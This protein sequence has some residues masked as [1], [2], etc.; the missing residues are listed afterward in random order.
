M[1][2]IFYYIIFVL[3]IINQDVF[4]ISS[5]GEFNKSKIIFHNA[6]LRIISED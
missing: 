3:Q 1:Y 5:K 6:N 4:I 2:I